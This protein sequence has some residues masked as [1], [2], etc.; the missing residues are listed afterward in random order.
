[1]GPEYATNTWKLLQNAILEIYNKNASGLSF[2]ELYRNSY[3][4]VLHKHGD[5][6]YD[7]LKQTVHDRLVEVCNKVLSVSDENLLQALN[8]QWEDHTQSMLMI[9]D[10]LMYMD[11]VYVVHNNLSPVYDVGLQKF[12]ENITRH[13][14]IKDR[15]LDS[16]LGNIEKE[17]RAEAIPRG[18]MKNITQMLVDLGIGS[19]SVYE[20][21][22][23]KHF[24]AESEKFYR[25][26]AQEFISTNSAPEYMKKVENRINEEVDRVNLYLDKTT[27]RKILDKIHSVLITEH[28]QTLVNMPESGLIFMLHADKLSDLK[29]MYQLLNRVE[30][31][32]ELMKTMISELVKGT[33]K[34]IVEHPENEKK[35]SV[36]VQS[37]IELKDKYDKILS[38]AFDND[39]HFILTVNQAFESFINAHPRSPEFLSLFIDEK[40]RKGLKGANEDEVEDTLK[41]VMV[42]FRFIQEK[43]VFEKYYKQHLAK[44]LLLGSSVSDDAEKGMISKLKTECGYQFTAKLEGMFTDMRTSATTMENFK[45]YISNLDKNTLKGIDINVHVLTT[46]FWPTQNTA[47]CTLSSEIQQCCQLFEKF[48]L[49]NHSGRRLTWQT[50]MGT[51]ELRS[52]F[53][54]KKH[55]LNVSTFQ[56]CILLL[57]NKYDT[58]SFKEIQEATNIPI[59]DLKRNLYTLSCAKYKILHKDPATAKFGPTDKYTFNND[60]KSKLFRVKVNPM[61]MQNEK[62]REQINEKINE[63]RKHLIEAAIVRVMKARNKLQHNNLVSEV[64]KQLSSRFNPPVNVIKKRVESLIEREYIERD[65]TD[66]RIYVYLA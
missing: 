14:N 19:K 44:R 61:P 34:T 57:F 27:E 21:D 8:E 37:L 63:D 43:D 53:G 7:G 66:R 4:M 25:I 32:H 5:K 9:R 59:Q 26:E 51:G 12:R 10:I 42:L 58:I 39:K 46:G 18:L 16:L 23:E 56:M 60:F 47:T 30:T 28:M 31:G 64:I 48:Y 36:F 22:F 3:N 1:M 33:G 41:K 13:V 17:R 6:L 49:N 35:P 11:R 55:E 40:L 65:K 24:L 38:Q 20:D 52:H 29:R 54:T 15:L 50:N 62:E 2:E 45:T